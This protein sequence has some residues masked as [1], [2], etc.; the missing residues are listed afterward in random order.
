ME[1]ELMK[2]FKEYEYMFPCLPELIKDHTDI[3]IQQKTKGLEESL[4]KNS[5]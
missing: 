1:T 4:A 5:E 3:L 2:I